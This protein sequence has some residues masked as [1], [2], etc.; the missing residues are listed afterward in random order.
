MH[1]FIK[2]QRRPTLFVKDI[3]PERPVLLSTSC[4]WLVNWPFKTYNNDPNV[5][6]QLEVVMITVVSISRVEKMKKCGGGYMQKI[7]AH[8]QDIVRI[9]VSEY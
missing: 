8:L 3:L 7:I 4:W 1:P 6:T 9:I 5:E 2:Y